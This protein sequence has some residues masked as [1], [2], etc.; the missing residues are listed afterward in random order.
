MVVSKQI[1]ICA[2]IACSVPAFSQPPDPQPSAGGSQGYEGPSILSRDQSLIGER[3]GKLLDFRLYGSLT[4]VYDSGLTALSTDQNGK[5]LD[6]G[7]NYGTEVGFGAFGSKRWRKDSI[8]L[9]YHGAYRHYS[10]NSYFDGTDQFLNLRY[11]RILTRRF[12][13][14]LKETSGITSQSNGSFS[15]LPLTTSDLLAVPTNELFD[16]RTY[17]T[18]SR[19]TLIWQKTARLSFSAGG[20][21]YAV[22]RHSTALAGLTG[23]GAHGDIAYRVTRRQTVNIAYNFTHYDEQHVFGFADIQT[24]TAGYNIGIGKRYDIGLS[25]GASYIDY[26]GLETIQVDPAIVAIIGQTSVVQNF[27]RNSVLPTGE[28]R[29]QRR[30]NRSSVSLNA[31][32]GITPGNGVFLT[33]RQNAAGAQYSFTGPKRWTMGARL[34]Y[35]ELSAL[36]QTIGKY[37]GYQGGVGGTYRLNGLMHLEFRYDYRH[38][39]TQNNIFQKDSHRVSLGL[40]FSTGERPLPIW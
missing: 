39:T 36:G 31:S 15:Y 11:G 29:L 2:W 30:F 9:E 27:Q 32:T 7:G 1:I 3:S 14:D 6:T 13:L 20:D 24:F 22:R 25:F 21:A 37:S 16:N 4:G 19:G 38:Y 18:Q 5:L 12:T 28:F 26:R 8:D 23:Y 35:N 10:T 40:A 33:S 34:N 17:Y